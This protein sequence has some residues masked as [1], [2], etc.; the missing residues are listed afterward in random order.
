MPGA[1]RLIT[2]AALLLVAAAANL[3]VRSEPTDRWLPL[4]LVGVVGGVVAG[5]PRRLWPLPGIWLV[6]CLLVTTTG[7]TV[8]GTALVVALVAGAVA[9]AAAIAVDVIPFLQKRRRGAGT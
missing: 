6:A 5:A 1:V 2:I 9:L 8:D 7:A 3:V 4:L